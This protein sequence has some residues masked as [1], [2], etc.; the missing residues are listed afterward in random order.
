V[1]SSFHPTTPAAQQHFGLTSRGCEKQTVEVNRL[2][3]VFDSVCQGIDRPRVFL[4][5]DT[6]GSDLEVFGGSTGC[7]ENIG[8]LQ[9]EVSLVP[10]YSPLA[11]VIIGGLVSSTLLARIVTPVMYKLVA[12]QVVEVAA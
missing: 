11:W 1:F 6:Q 2:D 3:G 10:M 12:P 5:M 7:L 9:T 4:K 8:G